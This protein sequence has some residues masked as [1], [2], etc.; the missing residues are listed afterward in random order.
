MR[1]SE[2]FWGSML[3][4]LGGLF[5][6]R[7]AGVLR[8]DVLGWFWPLLV[9]GAG[10]W[11][12]VGGWTSSRR[13]DD[14]DQFRVPLRGARS[15]TLQIDH[16]VGHV[17]LGAAQAN[18][19]FLSGARGPGMNYTAD[20]AGDRLDVR[21]QAGPSFIPFVGP[22]GGAWTYEVNP[23][24]PFEFVLHSGASRLDI[25]LRELQVRRMSFEG[26]ASSLN[27]VLPEAAEQTE[28]GLQAG[29]ASIE[30]RVP[31]GVALQLAANSVGSLSVDESRFPA[32]G[33][34]V[35]QSS[36]FE[37]AAHRVRVTLDGGATSL[38][39]I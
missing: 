18:D 11:I 36:D 33:P 19:N 20:L 28:V 7:A 34:N 30:I 26:G 12:L 22:D 16:G 14:R 1:R 37:T 10:V 39:V 17:R 2:V 15:A 35:F 6:L 24:I 5:W 4:I 27:L 31:A 13:R 38:R 29:A 32:L 21:I 25:D 8:G 3:V 9:A 23:S